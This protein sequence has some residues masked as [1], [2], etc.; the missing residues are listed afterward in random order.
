[1]Y[2][3]LDVDASPRSVVSLASFSD[4]VGRFFFTLIII[5]KSDSRPNRKSGT[6]RRTKGRLLFAGWIARKVT[7]ASF[8]TV[9]M[10]DNK[11]FSHGRVIATCKIIILHAHVNLCSVPNELMNDVIKIKTSYFSMLNLI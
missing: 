4:F 5:A 2:L 7:P 8:I 10:M 11:C 3:S 1:M 9:K 6:A